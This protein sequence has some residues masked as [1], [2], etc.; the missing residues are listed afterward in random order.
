MPPYR[1]SPNT[2]ITLTIGIAIQ[3]HGWL[4]C[5]RSAE[6]FSSLP[7][8]LVVFLVQ[9]LIPVLIVWDDGCDTSGIIVVLVNGMLA[10]LGSTFMLHF[11]LALVNHVTKHAN[12]SFEAIVFSNHALQTQTMNFFNMG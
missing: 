10:K 1:Y 9:F 5:S 6:F 8:F 2:N 4:W 3:S 11:M 12:L 7:P